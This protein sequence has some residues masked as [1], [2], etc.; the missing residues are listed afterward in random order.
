V[1]LGAVMAHAAQDDDALVLQ[2]SLLIDQEFSG[3]S[4]PVTRFGDGLMKAPPE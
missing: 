4:F 1:E 2:L 3:V